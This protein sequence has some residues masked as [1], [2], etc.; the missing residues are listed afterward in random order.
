[1]TIRGTATIRAKLFVEVNIR[2]TPYALISISYVAL[3]DTE[4]M[5]YISQQI[6]QILK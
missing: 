4:Y 1:M 2:L 6:I 5:G 3:F